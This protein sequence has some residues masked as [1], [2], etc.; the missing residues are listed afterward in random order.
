MSYSL[1]Y[2]IQTRKWALHFPCLF[3]IFT[4]NSDTNTHVMQYVNDTVFHHFIV[5]E[6]KRFMKS[7]MK[8]STTTRQRPSD[9]MWLY[10]DVPKDEADVVHSM[11]KIW[12]PMDSI[13]QDTFGEARS[14]GVG[15]HLFGLVWV[16]WAHHFSPLRDGILFTQDHH[17]WRT[18]AQHTK[19]DDLTL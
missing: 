7:C 19:A 11:L 6:R 8:R 5:W 4:D 2:F 17:H 18:S 13:L 10:V 15:A 9:H 14:H 12:G 3:V 16:H 1:A